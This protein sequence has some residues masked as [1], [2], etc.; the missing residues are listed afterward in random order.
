MNT[1]KTPWSHRYSCAGV[2]EG[3]GADPGELTGGS[4]G[5]Y[6]AA[7]DDA[8]A[9]AKDAPTAVKENPNVGGSG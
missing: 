2:S 4:A 6:R 7:E 5:G 8:A 1:P 9:S 3:T